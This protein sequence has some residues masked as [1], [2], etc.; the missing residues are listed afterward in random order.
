[1][2]LIRDQTVTQAKE[3]LEHQIEF[4]QNIARYLGESTAESEA[5]VKR[6]IDLY[7]EKP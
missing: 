1:M 4:A 7:E 3:L 2:E 6:M 5:L